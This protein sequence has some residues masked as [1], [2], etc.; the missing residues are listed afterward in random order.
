M[1]K[2]YDIHEELAIAVLRKLVELDKNNPDALPGSAM[3]HIK[4][5]LTILRKRRPH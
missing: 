4:D 3:K 2:R 1:G 5:A